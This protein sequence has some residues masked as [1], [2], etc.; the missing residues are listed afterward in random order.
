M[1]LCTGNHELYSRR[2][3]PDTIEVQQMKA[4]ME[5]ERLQKKIERYGKV[6]T[7]H[8]HYCELQ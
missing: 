2:R 7:N 1:Q 4:Q 6:Y 5:E 3:R 8:V